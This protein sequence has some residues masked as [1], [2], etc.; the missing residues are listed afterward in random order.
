MAD[1]MLP[2]NLKAPENTGEEPRNRLRKKMTPYHLKSHSV[3]TGGKL[4]LEIFTNS[5]QNNK[6]TLNKYGQTQSA[7]QKEAR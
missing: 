7:A 4:I 2:V 5:N 6:N 1:L 3:D